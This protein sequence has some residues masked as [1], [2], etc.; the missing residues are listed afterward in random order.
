ML[1]VKP[2][3]SAFG[4]PGE[5]VS[6]K[7]GTYVLE[8]EGTDLGC[9]L[10]IQEEIPHPSLLE[11]D[12]RGKIVKQE[13]WSRLRIEIYD[14]AKPN[15][16]LTSF[17]DEWLTVDLSPDIFKHLSFPIL[18]IVKQPAKIQFMVVGPAKIKLEMKNVILR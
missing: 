3:F 16:P 2:I 15:E 9:N 5:K 12:I 14:R 18:G 7:N 11:L 8:G 10:V 4:K 17:E 6:E 13:R 1:K